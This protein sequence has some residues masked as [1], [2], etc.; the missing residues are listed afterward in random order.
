MV[1]RRHHEP[2][3]S[4][5]RPCLQRL[6]AAEGP[7]PGVAR[8]RRERRQGC[9]LEQLPS[10]N[11]HLDLRLDVANLRRVSFWKTLTK[12]ICAPIGASGARTKACCNTKGD[13]HGS[14]SGAINIEVLLIQIEKLVVF[15]YCPEFHFGL[16]VAPYRTWPL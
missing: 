7:R 12:K 1:A 5:S 14:N 16:S 6:L 8:S 4:G 3:L 10:F 11:H 9:N 15:Q 2:A 13:H